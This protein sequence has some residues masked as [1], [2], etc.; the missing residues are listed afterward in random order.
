MKSRE[1]DILLDGIWQRFGRT[2]RFDRGQLAEMASQVFNYVVTPDEISRALQI[3]RRSHR[4]RYDVSCEGYGQNSSWRLYGVHN[5]GSR[6]RREITLE[7][8]DYTIT[9]A[10]KR[11]AS[12]LVHEVL[13]PLTRNGSSKE[14][15]RRLALDFRSRCYSR[16]AA[17]G[18]S[19]ADI[20]VEAEAAYQPVEDWFVRAFGERV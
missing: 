2:G 7:H 17:T 19:G 4:R 18:L 11:E 1:L 6:R 13:P 5:H 15:C 16:L 12:D 20:A 9:D 10:L 14:E 3:Y 8:K